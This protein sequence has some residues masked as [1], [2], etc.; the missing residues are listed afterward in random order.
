VNRRNS[1]G[2]TSREADVL[3]RWD[4]GRSIQGIARDTSYPLSDIE[5][6]VSMF[7]IGPVD[8]RHTPSLIE[9]NR[10]YVAAVAA[11]GRSFAEACHA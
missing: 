7:H 1:N 3:A 9:A 8:R 5:R 11:T 6:I 2:L 4:A 10:R